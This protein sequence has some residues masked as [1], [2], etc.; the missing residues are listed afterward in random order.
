MNYKVLKYLYYLKQP[1]YFKLEKLIT[2]YK[3]FLEELKK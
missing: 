1:N 2:K 3:S